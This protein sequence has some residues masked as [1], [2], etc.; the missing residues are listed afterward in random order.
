MKQGKGLRDWSGVRKKEEKEKEDRGNK[1][2]KPFYGKVCP[3]IV[4][5]ERGTRIS[6]YWWRQK[7]LVSMEMDNWKVY[8]C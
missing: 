4:E 3:N 5:G 1:G 2:G 6:D 7:C 8:S